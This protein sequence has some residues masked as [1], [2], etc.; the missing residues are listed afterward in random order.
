MHISFLTS[1]Y[2]HIKVTKSAGICSSLKNLVTELKK[3]NI[4]ITLFIYGQ[5]E[6]A[7]FV[8]NGIN[9]HLIKHIKYKALGWYLYRKHIQSYINKVSAEKGIDL[10]EAPDWTGITAFMKFNIPLVIRLHGTDAYFCHLEERKQKKKNFF[11]EKNALTHADAIVSVSRYTANMTKEIFSLKKEMTIIYN[12]INVENFKPLQLPF[13]PYSILYFGTIIRKK[14]V[15]ELAQAF[16]LLIDM[17]PGVSLILLGKDVID[18]FKKR[19]T[20]ELF[21]DVLTEKAK[22]RVRYIEEVHYSEVTE[23]I[24]KANLVTLP[25]FAEAFPMTW[26]EA[27]AMEKALVT[28]NIGWANE[29]MVDGETGFKVDPKNREEYATKMNTLIENS[30]LSVECGKNARKKVLE[31]FEISKIVENN[32]DFFKSIINR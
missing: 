3:K 18:I 7:V 28:S 9:F 26:L 17:N 21:Y 32:I 8:E 1:E 5:E 6:N 22:K 12:G 16:N 14:G 25:S 23:I 31:N 20:L 24:A 27:M 4:T 29:I 30:T 15:L 10:L 13:K 11:F 19:S 2:P